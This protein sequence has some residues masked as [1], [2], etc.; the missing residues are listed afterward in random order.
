MGM[1]TSYWFGVKRQSIDEFGT[2]KIAGEA[3]AVYPIH[4][5]CGV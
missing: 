5:F 4:L 3:T 1:L 2:K